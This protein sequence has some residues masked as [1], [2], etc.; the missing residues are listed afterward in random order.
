MSEASETR[1]KPETRSLKLPGPAEPLV[2]SRPAMPSEIPAAAMSFLRVAVAAQWH[3]QALYGLGWRTDS[4]G[5]LTGVLRAS[6]LVKARRGDERVIALWGTP[7]PVPEGVEPPGM[8]T[9]EEL[10]AHLPRGDLVARGEATRI[11]RLALLGTNVTVKWAYEFG[12][13]WVRPAPP[14]GDK[15]N[16]E[17]G[18]WTA[19]ALKQAVTSPPR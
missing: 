2:R 16:G 14:L 11:K 8:D 19:T 4:G 12:T 17:T 9:P 7:W 13:H 1:K 15:G 3:A 10:A 6:L 5:H 18:W